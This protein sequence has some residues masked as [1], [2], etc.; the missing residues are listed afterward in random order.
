MKHIPF[1][2]TRRVASEK[3]S[4]RRGSDD[5]ANRQMKYGSKPDSQFSSHFGQCSFTFT[6][7]KYAPFDRARRLAS[8]KLSLMNGSCCGANR[9]LNNNK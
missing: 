6:Q 7:L 2:R 5:G 4:L 1:D 8:N 3:L 9:Q